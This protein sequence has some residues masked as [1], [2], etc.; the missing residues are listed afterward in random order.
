[1]TQFLSTE[2]YFLIEAN[3]GIGEDPR[4]GPLVFVVLQNY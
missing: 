1:M 2:H 4:K 3:L